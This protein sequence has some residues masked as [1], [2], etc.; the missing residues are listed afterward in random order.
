MAPARCLKAGPKNLF[1]FTSVSLIFFLFL[2]HAQ[3]LSCLQSL[4]Q[5]SVACFTEALRAPGLPETTRKALSDEVTFY[6]KRIGDIEEELYFGDLLPQAPSTKPV[7]PSE[8]AWARSSGP[9]REGSVKAE[10]GVCGV[11]KVAPGPV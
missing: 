1:S 4:N 10:E 3:R 2:A 5:E 8:G 11:L 6:N 9:P 7:A